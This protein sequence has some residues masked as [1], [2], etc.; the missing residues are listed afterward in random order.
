MRDGSWRDM[1]GSPYVVCDVRARIY[2]ASGTT[3]TAGQLT[4]TLP[5]GFF[6]AILSVQAQAVR[7]S[8][9][10]TQACFAQVLTYNQTSVAVA[11][12]ESKTT[13]VLLGG[14]VEG[15]EPTPSATS[16]LLTVIGI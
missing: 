11:V 14:T 9:A 15:L 12:F 5:A 2:S 4:F 1:N 8:T 3:N 6:T 10:A 16:V 13:G 7:N